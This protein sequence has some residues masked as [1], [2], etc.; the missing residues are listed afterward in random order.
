MFQGSEPST[1]AAPKPPKPPGLPTLPVAPP[2]AGSP[3]TP[4][5]TTTTTPKF[6]GIPGVLGQDPSYQQLLAFDTA[7]S[8]EDL[9]TMNA[10]IAQMQG[11]YGSDNDP[12]SI[13]G[14]IF[15]AY[16]DR[17]MYI[18]NTLAGHGMI[19]SGETG[20]Q[21]ARATLAYQQQ[22]LDA[23]MKLEQYIQGLQDAYNA[24]QRQRKFNEMQASWQAVQNWLNG[25]PPVTTTTPGTEAVPPS[26]G[27][28]VWQAPPGAPLPPN[29]WTGGGLP[30][31]P[32][33]PWTKGGL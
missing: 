9:A 3:A 1:G 4:P 6:P 11:Y 33:N 12:L 31:L 19:Q 22:E 8:G 26:P 29:P 16:K 23:R 30:P 2:S 25:N 17:N 24:A 5:T 32:P 15:Q 21:A 27:G 28:T 14:R 13:L 20:W 7:A 18:A 10:R